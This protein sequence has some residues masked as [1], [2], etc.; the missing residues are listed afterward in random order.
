MLASES[1]CQ[2]ESIFFSEF[3]NRVGRTLA[4]QEP[5]HVISPEEFDAIS[6]Y[7]IPKPQLCDQLIMLRSADRAVMC[8]PVCLE[9]AKYER[10][11]LMFSLG[12]VV[13]CHPSAADTEGDVE[14]ALCSRYGPVLHKATTHLLAL[15]RESA[16]LSDATRKCELAHLLPPIFH[17]L[18]D[19][20]ACAVAADAGN[21]IHL[22]L[23]PLA[24]R[25]TC[26]PVK[27]HMVPL[28]VAMPD[29]AAVR[30]WDLSIQK[31]LRWIDGTNHTAAIAAAA[32][33][34][35]SVVR[36]GL[37]ALQRCGWVRLVDQFDLSNAYGALP[38]LNAL[39]NDIT[40]RDAVVSAV[41]RPGRPPP[42]WPDVL[43]LYAACQPSSDGSGWRSV[44]QIA[45][46]LPD[47]AWRVDLRALVQVGLLNG[48]I[49]Q[50]RC[51]PKR[52]YAGNPS[53]A[54]EEA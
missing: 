15:E 32:R 45:V 5:P 34:D 21:T 50:I 41:A 19:R 53:T 29:S 1:T 38:A 48:L 27:E 22:H 12:L 37:E 16:M 4:F 17:G 47:A 28:L 35:L 30:G 51:E 36:Q 10:N 49:R 46:M 43:R 42:S 14:E 23:P 54:G 6:D 52:R 25:A 20:G 26:P 18:R 31:L 7:L 24:L 2:L 8:W 39:A 13:R 11:A 33:V 9:D 3:D 40:A 44:H